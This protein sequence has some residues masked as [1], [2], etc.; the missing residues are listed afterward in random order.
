[1]DKISLVDLEIFAHHGVFDFEKENGQTFIV[2]CECLLDTHEAGTSD[3]LSASLDYG[4]LAHRLTALFQEKTFD[5]IEAAAE[6]CA[7][8][9]LH[10]F[11]LIRSLTLTIKKPSAPV[12][13]PLAYPAVTITRGWTPAILALGSN[14]EPRQEHLDAALKLLTDHPDI[15][16]LRIAP[17]IETDPVGYTDQD[18]FLNGA[19]LIETLLTPHAL[20]DAIHDIE[21]A[22]KRERTIHWGPRTLDIDIIYYDDLLL[23]S[24]DLTIPHP[25]CMERT[26]VM[27]PVI[28]I[29][30][31]WIDPRYGKAISICWKEAQE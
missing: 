22:R 23:T 31:Y 5:L 9:L 6:H 30:P 15:R 14:I 16:C 28:T 10:E 12:N 11:S 3:N 21:A 25:L 19:V 27:E 26:F 2:S 1:M 29:A 13:L 17:W 4:A 24:D 20:L 7:S 18:R 8:A